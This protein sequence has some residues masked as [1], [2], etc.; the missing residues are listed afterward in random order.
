MSTWYFIIATFSTRTTPPWGSPAAA[1]SCSFSLAGRNSPAARLKS[2]FTQKCHKIETHHTDL[3]YLGNSNPSNLTLLL[4]IINN[5]KLLFNCDAIFAFVLTGQK[6]ISVHHVLQMSFSLEI[7]EGI[8]INWNPIFNFLSYII[9]WK[10]YKLYY[11][12]QLTKCWKIFHTKMH[13]WGRL[14]QM[15]SV[16]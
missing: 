10:K 12:Y 8:V 1:W 4:I 14:I 3:L 5:N 15:K 11:F 16:R 2:D 6:K 7:S 9:F 13:F